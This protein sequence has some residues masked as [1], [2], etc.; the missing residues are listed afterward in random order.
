MSG[1][2]PETNIADGYLNKNESNTASA[3]LVS[4]LVASSGDIVE[5]AV[6]FK[7]AIVA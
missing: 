4:A 5:Y 6:T 2:T 1:F 7:Q 3:N